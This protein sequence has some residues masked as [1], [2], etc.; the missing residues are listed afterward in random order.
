M[1][2]KTQSLGTQNQ[3]NNNTEMGK[4]RKVNRNQKDTLEVKPL[5]KTKKGRIFVQKL[6][7]DIECPQ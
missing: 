2:K 4:T 6:K 5:P 7:I 3:V 1:K